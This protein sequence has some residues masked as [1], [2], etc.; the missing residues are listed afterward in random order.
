MLNYKITSKLIHNYLTLRYNPEEINIHKKITSSDLLNTHSDLGGHKTELL[1]KKAI[2]K[3]I[4]D[5][6]EPLALSLSSG[7]DSSLTLGLLRHVFPS[8]KLISICVVFKDAYDESKQA[9]LIAKKF[10]STFKIVT[11]DSIF[12]NMPELISIAKKPRWNTYQHYVAKEAK[13]YSNIL[14]NG[15]GADEVFAGYTFRYH[16]FLNLSKLTDDWKT[17]VIN[18]LECHNRD[19]VPDQKNIFGKKIKF[20]WNV[21]HNYLKPYFRNSLKPI[22][23]V[24]LADFNGKLIYDF[25]PTGQKILQHYGLLGISPFLDSNVVNFGLHLQLDQ[26]YDAVSNKGKLTLRKITNR[27]GV[28]HIDEK[29]G[30]S[31]DLLLDWN[32]NGKQIAE[33]IL[34]DKKSYVYG[35]NIINH[36]WILNAFDRVDSD[37]DIRY[38]SKIV[39]IL[40]LEIY[41]Q[42]FITK[43]I[44]PKTIL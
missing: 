12:K 1:L 11:V 38:L 27:L 13:K 23:Q 25:I 8:R 2:K 26:K 3:S 7:I 18:Y 28:E 22:Q 32:R 42:L 43:Q 5:N 39:S 10:N 24:F 31:P 15:D 14:V 9:R 29:K 44:S 35:N 17:K 4:P 36:G 16:K 37:G 21:I 41:Y 6:D 34:L 20:D 19:W 33:R 30:F 40:A